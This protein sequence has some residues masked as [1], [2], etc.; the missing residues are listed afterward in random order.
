M[1]DRPSERL[2]VGSIGKAHGLGGDVHVRLITD[3]AE[4]L[5]PG[6]TLATDDGTLE[7]VTSR[8]HQNGWLVRFHG[9]NDRNA[10]EALRGVV[11]RAEPIDDPETLWV[12]E[13]IGA[14]VVEIDG[15]DRGIVESVQE[16]PASDLLVLESGALVPLTF[17][18]DFAD[19]VVTVDTPP[20]LFELIGD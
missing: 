11:L 17:V 10:A 20:G 6:S 4:R 19:G 15:T 8:P 16:N 1:A 3:R 18:A 14:R 9:V 5:E 12:H 13:L 2:E 7:V